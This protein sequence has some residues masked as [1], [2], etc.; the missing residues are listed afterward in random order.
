MSATHPTP[1]PSFYNS[2]VYAYHGESASRIRSTAT[3]AEIAHYEER[4][5]LAPSGWVP[6]ADERKAIDAIRMAI[7]AWDIEN[8]EA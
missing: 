5:V 6:N 3:K 4:H 2:G 8:E 7:E 1:R